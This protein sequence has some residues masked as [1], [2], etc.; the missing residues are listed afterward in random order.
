[1]RDIVEILVERDNIDRDAAAKRI[2]YVK[3][4]IDDA[5]LL[6]NDEE[7]EDIIMD[8]LGLEPDYLEELL[9]M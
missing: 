9:L 2:R 8:E 4:L 6:G 7:V 1:M 5:I 3:T